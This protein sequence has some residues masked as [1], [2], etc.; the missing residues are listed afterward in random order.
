VGWEIIPGN[1]LLEVG[2]AHIFGGEFIDKAPNSNGGDNDYFYT[3][4][5]LGF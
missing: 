4:V 3:Q 2:Y 1:V 5:E